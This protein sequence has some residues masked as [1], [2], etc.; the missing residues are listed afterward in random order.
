MDPVA[1]NYGGD[2]SVGELLLGMSPHGRNLHFLFMLWHLLCGQELGPPIREAATTLLVSLK[3]HK[4]EKE[5][6]LGN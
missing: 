3:S 1:K 5:I 6:T 2:D 4:A